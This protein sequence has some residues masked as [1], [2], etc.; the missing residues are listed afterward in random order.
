VFIRNFGLDGQQP[1]S[2]IDP[3]PQSLHG[4]IPVIEKN[5]VYCG[6]GTRADG[7]LVILDR[8]ELLNP[9]VPLLDPENPTP[10]ELAAPLI[11]DFLTSEFMG[12]HTTFPV[13]G[14]ELPQLGPENTM[15]DFIVLVNEAIAN[16]CNESRQMA[17]MVDITDEEH[18][19]P[20]SNMNVD[21]DEGDYCNV[22]GRFGAHAS[23]ESFTEVFYRKLVAISW[24]NAGVRVWD[25]TDPFNPSE[26]A[27]Y[28]PDTTANTDPRGGKIAIQTNNVEVDER[29]LIYTADRANTGLHILELTGDAKKIADLP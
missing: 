22:G 6:H 11:V 27:Y 24:F 5:R 19:Y 28:V 1:G 13:L 26:A 20:V 2:T 8:D 7:H 25:I 18:P 12:A 16:E 10:D 14:Y 3:V 23:N 21:M 9:S 29:G 4:C 17:Y 15:R